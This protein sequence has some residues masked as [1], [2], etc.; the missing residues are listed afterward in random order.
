MVGDSDVTCGALHLLF[1]FFSS[2]TSS[3]ISSLPVAATLRAAVWLVWMCLR[4]HLTHC[5]NLSHRWKG[6]GLVT[7]WPRNSEHLHAHAKRVCVDMP[8]WTLAGVAGAWGLFYVPVWEVRGIID[9]YNWCPWFP[10]S[11]AGTWED[12]LCVCVVLAVQSGCDKH[13]GQGD[14]HRGVGSM[15]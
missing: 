3:S 11:T 6:P 4:L 13:P 8:T 12:S 15:F 10:G 2:S 1:F 5:T 7:Q 14:L 9:C